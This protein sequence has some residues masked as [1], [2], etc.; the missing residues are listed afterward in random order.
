[1]L[2]VLYSNFKQNAVH[3][4]THEILKVFFFPPVLAEVRVGLKKIPRD[5]ETL[6]TS[7]GQKGR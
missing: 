5:R 4:E 1:M 3:K 6:V 7:P 2:V